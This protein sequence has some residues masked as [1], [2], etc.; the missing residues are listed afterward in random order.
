LFKQDEIEANVA[1]QST[2]LIKVE[3]EVAIL[4]LKE[5]KLKEVQPYK[6]STVLLG[7]NLNRIRNWLDD[8]ITKDSKTKTLNQ[9]LLERCGKL[10]ARNDQVKKDL[11]DDMSACRY[12]E[13]KKMLDPVKIGGFLLGTPITL[14]SLTKIKLDPAVIHAGEIGL[15]LG[16]VL[17]FHHQAKDLCVSASKAIA[18]SPRRIKSLGRSVRRSAFTTAMMGSMAVE[19]ARGFE[20]HYPQRA[21]VNPRT[22]LVAKL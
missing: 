2:S 10:I 4:L 18:K 19:E 9:A 3:T 17:A 6:D 21:A 1:N 13:G 11:S 22:Y 16:V 15:A 20:T 7:D 12:A 8:K 14:A 5:H